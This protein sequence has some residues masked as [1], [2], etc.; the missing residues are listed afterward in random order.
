LLPATLPQFGRAVLFSNA[1]SLGDIGP[2][3]MLHSLSSLRAHFDF[4]IT[5]SLWM[6]KRFMQFASHV[7]VEGARVRA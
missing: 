2:T 1:G 3:S 5:S 6:E 4:N 7:C